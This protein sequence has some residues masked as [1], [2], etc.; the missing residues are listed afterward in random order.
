MTKAKKTKRPIEKK[1]LKKVSGGR[2][3]I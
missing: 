2:M 3:Q 1:D